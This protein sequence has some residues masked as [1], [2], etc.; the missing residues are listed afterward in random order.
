MRTL[1]KTLSL[2]LV[3]AMVLGLCVVGASAYNKV[4]DFTDDVAKI[5][6]AY[7]EAVGVLTGIGVIDGMTETAFEPQGTYTREQAAKIIAYMMLGKDKADSL[8]CTVAPFE[9]VA[10]NRWSAG[11]IAFCVE[12]GIIDG[13]TATTYEPTG[14]LTGFQ[15]AK[16][17][18]CAIGFGVKGE[19]TGSSWSVNTAL[20]AHKVDLFK[21]DLDGADHTALRREQAAL[22]AFNVLTNVKKVA[23]SPNVT[24]YVYGI[25][26]YTT[27]N[28]IGSTLG[29]DVFGL[30]KDEGIITANEGTGAKYTVLSKGYKGSATVATIA[31]NTGIDMYYHAARVWSV[32]GVSVFVYDLAK[33][34]VST[35]G[36]AATAKAAATSKVG[37]N[38]ATLGSQTGTVLYEYALIDNSAFLKNSYA[39]VSFY[40]GVGQLGVTNNINKTIQVNGT[41]VSLS[42]IWS[43]ISNMAKGDY[44]VYLVEGGQ[45]TILPTSVTSG[46]VQSYNNK[47]G[48]V[49]LTNGT[50]IEKSALTD[51]TK[52]SIGEA[53]IGQ[54]YAFALDSHGHY[55]N[56]SKKGV[57]NLY[58]YTG[59]WMPTANFNGWVGE[60]TY[61]AQFV[62]VT[63]GE[64]ATLPVL[65]SFVLN[66]AKNGPRTPGFYD[67]D[68][69]DANGIYHPQLKTSA[70]SIYEGTYAISNELTFNA[71]TVAVSVPSKNALSKADVVYLDK[72]AKF[73]VAD[74]SGSKLTITPYDSLA[75]MLAAYPNGNVQFDTTAIT[76]YTSATGNYAGQV[77]FAYMG[78]ATSS[79]SNLF[80]PS[81]LD[82]NDYTVSKVGGK[83]IY[84]YN[85][86]FY[87][88]GALL[89]SVTTDQAP[90][91]FT[92]AGFYNFTV[93]NGL[94]SLTSQA[95]DAYV[96]LG[97]IKT[98]VDANY[99]VVGQARTPI[100]SNVVV[101]D[102]RAGAKGTA[103]EIKD[104]TGLI[105]QYYDTSI[106]MAYTV[107]GNAVNV[108]YVLDQGWQETTTISLGSAMV[109]AGWRL[110]D[111]S[112]KQVTSLSYKDTA[113]ATEYTLVNIYGI[114]LATGFDYKGYLTV[115]ESTGDNGTL[116]SAVAQADGSI[117]VKYAPKVTDKANRSVS[118]EF[119]S[120]KAAN[121][122]FSSSNTSDYKVEAVNAGPY[123]FGESIKLKVTIYNDSL[124]KNFPVDITFD[125]QYDGFDITV[126]DV[127][128]GSGAPQVVYVDVRTGVEGN[129]EMSIALA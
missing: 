33:T 9:D 108:I 101:V 4:E 22:Y 59:E 31:A 128:V 66:D 122:T 43:D 38:A 125:S 84:T 51:I 95:N 46:T 98:A 87:L 129:F 70:D 75:A 107:Y 19:F 3:V 10:A 15:W 109:N 123:N 44:V 80:L 105:S 106:S 68:V 13:M 12:Q 16:M 81:T 11:Y 62:N 41:A 58:F 111:S 118:V 74:G 100:S 55:Y 39:G 96:V 113:A 97:N 49:T 45:Y 14:T 117:L 20:V 61:S 57:A 90:Y 112:K 54:T 116:T 6:D 52:F 126:E 121:I 102:L 32:K 83:T 99:L 29:Q 93:K 30:Q 34:T 71:S 28:G 26:G 86:V 72:T 85:N 77:V 115:T 65:S 50:V 25:Q 48:A 120:L 53:N 36:A 73:F 63:T 78:T 35:C 114:K 24:S 110:L 89:S 17:L 88:N 42:N 94:W 18:L 2:V 67:V 119:T 76:V 127:Q 64:A 37:A 7:Y 92:S 8:G 40:Y 56:L 69:A 91:T 21:G 47:T 103:S 1:K 5:G 60:Y 82:A 79:G 23:Y 124:C 27:V 104:I